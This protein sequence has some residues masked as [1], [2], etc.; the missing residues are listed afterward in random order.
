MVLIMAY[1]CEGKGKSNPGCVVKDAGNQVQ[2][3][4][5]TWRSARPVVDREKCTG[6][7]T[8]EMY[9]PDAA[10]AVKDPDRKAVVDYDFCKGCLICK[11]VCPFK[12]IREELE[13]K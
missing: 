4:T 1:I 9:C 3:K 10:I 13:E 6:C 11:Q 5:G 2:N 7:K 8:C 12:A